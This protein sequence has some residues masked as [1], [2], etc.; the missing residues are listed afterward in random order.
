MTNIAK[1]ELGIKLLN[2]NFKDIKAF[3]S[4]VITIASSLA[5]GLYFEN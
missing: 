4:T 1:R 3:D 2:E 5:S